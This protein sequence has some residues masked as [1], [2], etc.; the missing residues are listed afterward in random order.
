MTPLNV[1]MP[2]MPVPHMPSVGYGVAPTVFDHFA[3]RFFRFP[4]T[5]SLLRSQ[6]AQWRSLKMARRSLWLRVRF[7]M[8][9]ENIDVGPGVEAGWNRMLVW[10]GGSRDGRNRDLTFCRFWG[11]W[12]MPFCWILHLEEQKLKI[13]ELND[14]DLRKCWWPAAT[15]SESRAERM[16]AL[17]E[18]KALE[19][20]R[21]PQSLGWHLGEL[22]KDFVTQLS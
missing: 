5:T 11:G 18:I 12:M 20:T 22:V 1:W 2:Y 17:R 7:V 8:R 15:Y 9:S 10:V 19:I 14:F 13:D 6:K 3:P 21:G 16:L 4:N